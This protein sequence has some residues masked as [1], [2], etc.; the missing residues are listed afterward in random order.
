M[1]ARLLKKPF[2]RA[3]ATNNQLFLS[4]DV[5]KDIPTHELFQKLGFTKQPSSGLVHWLPLGL[6]ILRNVENIIHTEMRRVDAEEVA[7]SSLSAAALWKTTGRW[8]NRELF[9]LQD[10]K[11][12]DYCLAP[13]CEEEITDIVKAH[14]GSYKDLPLIMYQVARKYRDEKRPRAGLLRGREFLMKDAYSFD[15]SETHALV[16]YDKVYGAYKAIFRTLKIPFAIAEADTGDIGGSLSHEWHYVHHSGEDS[17]FTCSSCGSTSN[18]EKTLALPEVDSVPVDTAEVR[19]FLNESKDTL[20][21]L[22]YPVG[23]TLV[24]LFLKEEIPDLNTKSTLTDE[25]T[26]AKFMEGEEII[27]KSIIRVMDARL[28]DRTILPD[29]PVPFQRGSFTTL[30]GLPL[31]EAREG[32][33]CYKCEEGRLERQKA[34]EVGHTFFLGTRYSAPLNATFTNEFGKPELM[35]MGCYGIGVSRII[36]AIAEVTRDMEG[37]VWP[38]TIAPFQVTIIEGPGKNYQQTVA[39]MDGVAQSLKEGGITV[40]RDFRPLERFGLGKKIRDSNLI[41]VPLVVI[42]G[43][44]LPRL[45][46]EVRGKRWEQKETYLWQELRARKQEAWQWEVSEVKGREKHIVHVDGFV[47][48]VQALLKDM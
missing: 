34:I 15:V 47:E 29:F 38:A 10:A 33:V 6:R 4:K 2:V 30:T 39:M 21:A 32:E 45:E 27:G 13:T 17:L 48:V 14:V 41:G 31:V 20:V 23:R 40:N 42:A 22:Y 18:I 46:I 8:D 28:H 16:T 35:S 3:Y 43:K 7:L 9:K 26:L 24:P 19:Y 44:A 5:S 25:E 1:L 37:F 36:A 12:A 11:G